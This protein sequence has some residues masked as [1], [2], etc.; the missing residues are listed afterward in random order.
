[1]EGRIQEAIRVRYG[2]RGRARHSD[3]PFAVF[4]FGCVPLTVSAR[5]ERAVQGDR[6]GVLTREG[7]YVQEVGVEMCG[8][9]RGLRASSL[10]RSVAWS[11][12]PGRDSWSQPRGR[13]G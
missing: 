4:R 9:Y 3:A 1:M 6:H 10:A 12:A 7:D 11:H 2:S 5:S 13:R 8:E